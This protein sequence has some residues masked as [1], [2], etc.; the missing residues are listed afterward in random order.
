MLDG[1]LSI[2]RVGLD[3][4]ISAMELRHYVVY[5]TRVILKC[6]TGVHY[7]I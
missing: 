1:P 2:S 6:W 3:N 4:V 5:V 7:L